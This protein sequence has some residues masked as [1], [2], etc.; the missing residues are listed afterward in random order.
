MA[1]QP[2]LPPRSF[3]RK[4]TI[5]EV[6]SCCF[7]LNYAT[8][9]E[10]AD[11]GRWLPEGVDLFHS[12]DWAPSAGVSFPLDTEAT[13]EAARTSSESLKLQES[14]E[15]SCRMWT[16]RWWLT[17]SG[18]GGLPAWPGS[19]HLF[20][21]LHPQKELVRLSEKN[22]AFRTDR[23]GNSSTKKGSHWPP[24]SWATQWLISQGLVPFQDLFVC[25]SLFL[26][27][28]GSS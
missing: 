26:E 15:A 14:L 28:T 16:T 7:K 12:S 3:P 2:V 27:C 22:E 23:E 8:V 5:K 13:E 21:R 9:G 1:I 20:L 25:C 10:K 11:R 19:Q 6:T 18:L 17:G 24:S 4:N